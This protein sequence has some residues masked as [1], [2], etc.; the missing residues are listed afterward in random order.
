MLVFYDR[1]GNVIHKSAPM[2]LEVGAD[3]VR[4]TAEK[5]GQRDMD[6]SVDVLDR[7]AKVLVVMGMTD[8]DA[9]KELENG[10]NPALDRVKETVEHLVKGLFGLHVTDTETK[11]I[12]E[13]LRAGVVA[14]AGKGG[15]AP[16]QA[17]LH[18]TISRG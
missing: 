12:V 15:A 10:I 7:T 18:Y 1:K 17:G 5:A 4:G 6:V 9:F 14:D 11:E 2:S 16:Q 8:T 3:F 13:R